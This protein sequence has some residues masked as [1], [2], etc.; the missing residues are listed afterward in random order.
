MISSAH[1]ARLFQGS[2]DA[3][4]WAPGPAAAAFERFAGSAAACPARAGMHPATR[5]QYSAS[6][7]RPDACHLSGAA[8]RLR[9]GPGETWQS[10]HMPDLAVLAAADAPPRLVIPFGTLSG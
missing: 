7:P 4:L 1:R 6:H 5:C 9:A 2:G 10:L 3:R 8:N